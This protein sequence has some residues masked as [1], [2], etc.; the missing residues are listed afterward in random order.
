LQN[1]DDFGRIWLLGRPA[2]SANLGTRTTFR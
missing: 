1:F 2:C